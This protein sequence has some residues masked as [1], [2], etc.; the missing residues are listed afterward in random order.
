MSV[1]SARLGISAISIRQPRWL[2]SNDWFGGTIPRKFVQH[3]GTQQRAI[4]LDDEVTMAVQA[5]KILQRETGCDLQ[6]CVALIFV[7]PSFIPLVAARKYLER[8]RVREES[9]QRA[10]KRLAGRLGLSSCRAIG[11][12]WFCAGYVKALAILFRSLSRSSFAQGK[13]ALVVTASRISRI[14]DYE[15][16]QTGALFGDIGTATLV[17]SS[18]SQRYPVRFDVLSAD[19]E[20]QAADGVYFDFHLREN[21]LSPTPDGGRMRVPRRLVFSLDGLGVADAAPRAMSVALRKSLAATGIRPEK[22]RFVVPHQAGTAIVRLTAMKLEEIGI[23]VETANG[24]TAHVGNLSSSSIP[25]ALKQLWHRLEGTIA[26]PTAAVGNPG[27]AEISQG[28]LL[29]EATSRN[30]KLVCAA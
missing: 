10:A 2:L 19:A 20:T 17:A 22:V 25:Y 4:S 8:D 6:D 1:V 7:S 29:L 18:D 15:C 28:C 14:T 13:F 9:V 16:K 3:T 26:C 12:N 27:M 5:T 11:I 30:Q 21:V 24:L 23:C